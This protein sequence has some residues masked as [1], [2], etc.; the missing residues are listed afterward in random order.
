MYTKE[1]LQ[2]ALAELIYVAATVTAMAD[3]DIDVD[4][5]KVAIEVLRE[6]IKKS[7]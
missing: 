4:A 3:P 5:I 6:E 7:A 1:Q 2:D